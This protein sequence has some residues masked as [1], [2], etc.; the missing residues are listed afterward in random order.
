MSNPA[1]PRYKGKPLLGLLEYYVLWAIGELSEKQASFMEEI[2]PKLRSTFH[3]E[4]DWQS[5][6]TAEMEFPAHLPTKI[7]E[8]WVRNLEIARVA[9]VHL[10]PQQFAEMFVD[11]N[12][13][14]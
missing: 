11:E 4:G 13:V 8:F 3:R 2:T 1:N 7:R 6:I 9:G 5:I 10:S 12:F 14:K